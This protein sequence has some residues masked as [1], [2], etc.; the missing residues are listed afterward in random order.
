[1]V[2]RFALQL[3]QATDEEKKKSKNLSCSSAGV[4]LHGKRDFWHV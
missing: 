2:I 3:T 1:M 4:R